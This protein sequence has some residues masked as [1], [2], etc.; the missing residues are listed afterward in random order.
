[1]NYI[2]EDNY[3]L[4]QGGTTFTLSKDFFTGVDE[5]GDKILNLLPGSIFC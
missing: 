3:E 1:M 5:F 2:S 4:V